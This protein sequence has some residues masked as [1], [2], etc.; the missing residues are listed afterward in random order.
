MAQIQ[1]L[2]VAIVSVLEKVCGLSYM[3]IYLVKHY[4]TLIRGYRYGYTIHG[5][6]IR[7][8]DT[9]MPQYVNF[10]KIRIHGHIFVYV[11][12]IQKMVELL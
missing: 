2:L 9:R 5:C 3:T 11:F 1:E 8:H 12:K 4:V 6:P 10:L 7:I